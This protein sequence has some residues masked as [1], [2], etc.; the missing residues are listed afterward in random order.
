MFRIRD[1]ETERALLEL[2]QG[3]RAL[4]RLL[5]MLEAELPQQIADDPQHRR[6][7]V[8]DEDRRALVHGHR[9]SS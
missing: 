2:L 9:G 7:I 1:H 3:S 8:D 6:I 4:A 5:D